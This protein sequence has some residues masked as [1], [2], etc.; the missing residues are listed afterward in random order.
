MKNKLKTFTAC[1]TLLTA[2]FMLLS[3]SS[4]L[5]SNIDTQNQ[6]K[7]YITFGFTQKEDVSASLSVRTIDPDFETSDFT[8]ITIKAL[9]TA[10]GAEEQ[11]LVSG[12]TYAEL[13]QTSLML[14]EGTYTFSAT[15]TAGFYTYTGTI[16]ATQIKIGSNPLSFTMKKSGTVTQT[17]TG[18]G[19]YS[20]SMTVSDT[21]VKVVKASLLSVMEDQTI[22]QETT[23]TLKDGAYV[24]EGDIETGNYTVLFT[25]YGDEEGLVE[26]SSYREVVNVAPSLTSSASRSIDKVNQVYPITAN[27]NGGTLSSGESL[28]GGYS[29]ISGTITLPTL[30]KTG[31]AFKGWYTDSDCTAGNEITTVSYA[32]N[33]TDGV[34]IYASWQAFSTDTITIA[35]KE[36]TLTADDDNEYFTATKWCSFIK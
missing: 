18:E 33:G 26:V 24:F 6:N 25:F 5:L 23:L 32:V 20:V 36:F 30:I 10:S 14:E 19:T 16:D 34:T 15:L 31:S 13:S 29:R 35:D 3:C 2:F 22:V 27:L 28:P 17:L 9:S 8:D 1:C 11:T 7:A 4:G 12:K 21:S